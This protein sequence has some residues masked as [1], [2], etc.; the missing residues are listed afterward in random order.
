MADLKL[1]IAR[2]IMRTRYELQLEA[3]ASTV[4]GEQM[5]DME[6]EGYIKRIDDLLDGLE[7]LLN[8]NV[9]MGERIEKLEQIAKDYEELKAEN[10]RLKSELAMRKRGQHGKKSEKPKVTSGKPSF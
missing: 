4:H 2:M 1:D 10:A 6:R 9:K 3:E 5:S 8:A 7:S